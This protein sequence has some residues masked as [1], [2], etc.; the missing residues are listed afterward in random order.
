MYLH[1]DTFFIYYAPFRKSKFLSLQPPE[2]DRDSWFIDTRCLVPRPIDS[3]STCFGAN[4]PCTV[5][6]E[7]QIYISRSV[8]LVESLREISGNLAIN[9]FATSW[10]RSL[11]PNI[12]PSGT[13]S[14][15]L[16]SYLPLGPRKGHRLDP[17]ATSQILPQNVRIPE[18]SRSE[19]HR[20]R[21]GRHERAVVSVS[22][23]HG[24]RQCPV[25]K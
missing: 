21:Q 18:G 16:G 3:V 14:I 15:K 6:T 5:S 7:I 25:R 8:C 20:S 24:F 10:S 23:W 1:I 12:T 19:E 4:S 11:A 9:I 22:D 13:F 17:Y 2:V